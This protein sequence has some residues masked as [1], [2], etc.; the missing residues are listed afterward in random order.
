MF[1]R[2]T[3]FSFVKRIDGDLVVAVV[4]GDSMDLVKALICEKLGRK[5]Q[6][7]NTDLI[8]LPVHHRYARI[9]VDEQ[10][11]RIVES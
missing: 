1:P 9:L 7:E 8:P 10:K 6:I 5:I 4:S 3:S 2:T 11:E